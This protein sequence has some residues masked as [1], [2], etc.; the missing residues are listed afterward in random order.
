MGDLLVPLYS[1]KES[2]SAGV[3]S[4]FLIQPPLAADQHVVTDWVKRSFGERWASET[5]IAFSAPPIRCFI[6]L[7]PEKQI[8]GFACY[9]TSWKG[10]FGPIGV[11]PAYCGRGIG[12]AL[13][14]RTLHAMKEAGYA[15][16]IIGGSGA[17]DY[18]E[19]TVGAI[20]IP[21]SSPGP[22]RDWIRKNPVE[23]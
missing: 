4:T 10:F 11:D 14:H 8:V 12:T 15:Y 22:Y 20:P 16:A 2:D 6:A 19:K 23:P 1:L 9:D 17:D 7:N 18:Y 21:N 5:G 3:E 13:L